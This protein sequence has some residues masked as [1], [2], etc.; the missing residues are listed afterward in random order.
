MMAFCPNCGSDGFYE[1]CSSPEYDE[2]AMFCV[3]ECR[4]CGYQDEGEWVSV[5]D[6]PP[7]DD[8]DYLRPEG[9]A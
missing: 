8:G 2:S 9:V 1:Q 3:N 4:Y 5:D 7:G 6:D